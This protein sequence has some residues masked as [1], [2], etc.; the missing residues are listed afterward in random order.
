M[1]SN[2]KFIRCDGREINLFT[3]SPLMFTP[4]AS[5]SAQ[6]WASTHND[7]LK[8]KMSALVNAL[9]ACPDKMGTRYLSAFPPEL[10]DCFEAIKPVWAPYYTID[11]ILAGLLDQHI[12]ANND[13]ALKM[14][15]WMVD[16]FYK[17][18]RM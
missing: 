8:E 5:A 9:S 2:H 7:T 3:H 16:Y 11:K 6:M 10:F 14:V 17:L 4:Q 12:F 15:T 18:F 13:Q 1:T